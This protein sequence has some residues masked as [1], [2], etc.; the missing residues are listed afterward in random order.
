MK[1]NAYKREDGKIG[2]RN[3]VLIMPS[4]ICSSGVARKIADAVEGAVTFEN[5]QGCAQ[6]AEDTAITLEILSGLAANANVYATIVIGLGCETLQE[7]PICDAIKAKTDKPLIYYSIQDEDGV[8]NTVAKGVEAAKKFVAEAN[9]MK[10]EECD[11]A[12]II[13][14]MECGGSDPTSGLSSNVVVG[15]VSDK[16]V[17]LGATTVLSE[18][19]EAI[20]AE[21]VLRE[22]GLTPEIGEKIYRMIRDTE[23]KYAK[24][25][26]EV[27]SGNPSPG[28]KDGGLTTLE[29]KSLGCIH[30]SGTRPFTDAYEYGQMLDKKGLLLMDSPGH[31]MVSVT[32]KVAG[33]AQIVFFTTGRGTPAGFPIAPVV[34]ISGNKER[35]QRYKDFIDFDTSA[36]IEG[37]KTIDELG[38]ELLAFLVEICNGKESLAEEND[39]S[40]VVINSNYSFC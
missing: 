34:K 13:L 22:R 12:G 32:G 26:A 10:R 9:K 29:E 39:I 20:G 21:D 37:T 35:V 23:E 14:G 8:K 15:N 16:L 24:M 17:D 38:D 36:S 25:G 31:D 33:G 27:R 11:L 6:V 5:A 3:H 40:A 19:V 2:I 1:I 7:K 28:N 18:T 30:K 4:C